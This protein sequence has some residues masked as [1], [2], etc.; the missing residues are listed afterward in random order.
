MGIIDGLLN[1]IRPKGTPA[2]S[3]DDYYE[4]CPHCY[5]TLSLQKGYDPSLKYWVCKGCG[6]MLI[7]PD[8]ESDIV[9]ICDEC[10][11]VMNEQEGFSEET[12]E[13]KCTECGFVNK[14][15]PS[16]IYLTEDEFQ[17][18]ARSPYRGLSDEDILELSLYQEQEYIGGKENVILVKHRE[19][20]ELFIKKLLTIYNK[21]IYAY[22][23]DH[24]ISNMPRVI[25]M[26]E[27]SNCLVVIEEYIKGKTVEAILESGLI[28][29]KKAVHITGEVCRILDDLHNLSTPIIHR[30]VKPSNIIIDDNENVYL[31]DMNVAKWF[32]P[33]KADDTRYMGT[34]YYAAPEQVGYGLSASSAKSD[35]YAVG[36]LL[37]VMI[38]GKFPKEEK[39]AGAVWNVIERCISL[40]AE[41]RYTA[42]ELIAELKK[43]KDRKSAEEAY[44]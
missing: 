14:I 13:W 20:G 36:M 1:K 15:D 38:T 34:Q 17:A 33:D 40:D 28:S 4:Y 24:P 42:K 12:P 30:D 32:D 27:S 10:G 37:N 41:N 11:A 3:S 21:S 19:T 5:A 6:E 31:L 25:K 35:I 44:R 16:E 43:L 9:W 18:E 8:I 2:E 23:M 26:Y 29:E 7:N 39:A 22:L